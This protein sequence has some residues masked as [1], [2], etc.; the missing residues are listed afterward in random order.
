MGKRGYHQ[1]ISYQIPTELTKNEERKIRIPSETGEVAQNLS[2]NCFSRGPEFSSHHL[3]R[4]A[5]N[6]VTSAQ[7]NSWVPTCT[8]MAHI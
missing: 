5:H 8:Y 3:W 1:N 6:L 4:A 2:H 7:R